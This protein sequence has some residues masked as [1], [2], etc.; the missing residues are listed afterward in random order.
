MQ[1][2]GSVDMGEQTQAEGIIDVNGRIFQKYVE[3]GQQVGIKCEIEGARV[4]QGDSSNLQL[5]TSL[6]GDP[7]VLMVPLSPA[8]Y[9]R[10]SFVS[11]SSR[12]INSS[13]T[14]LPNVLPDSRIPDSIS[15]NLASGD[16]ILQRSRL[17]TGSDIAMMKNVQGF[18]PIM[19]SLPSNLL[20]SGRMCQMNNT[21]CSLAFP[22]KSH[23]SYSNKIGLILSSESSH[24]SLSG[25]VSA[26]PRSQLTG[27]LPMRTRLSQVGGHREQERTNLQN[28][29]DLVQLCTRG[30]PL[31]SALADIR[32]VKE[33]IKMGILPNRGSLLPISPTW[34]T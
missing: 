9:R 31:D 10:P 27:S 23:R 2:A 1:E 21:K 15:I 13:Q 30:K 3:A 24:R 8:T 19:T 22:D 20:S 11:S 7:L 6:E 34:R 4:L 25:G 14:G 28:I 29:A 26:S 12:T 16:D 33:G 5:G 18:H 17:R 32:A